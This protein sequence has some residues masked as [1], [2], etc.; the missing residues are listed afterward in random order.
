[1]FDRIHQIFK[2][3]VSFNDAFYLISIYC[4][5]TSGR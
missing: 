2:F 4:S 1:M 3:L 5:N